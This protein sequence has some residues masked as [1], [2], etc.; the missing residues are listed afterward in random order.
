MIISLL[1]ACG[2]KEKNVVNEN[3][4]SIIDNE[5]L[6]MTEANKLVKEKI[7]IAYKKMGLGIEQYEISNANLVE[8]VSY[9]EGGTFDFYEIKFRLKPQNPEQVEKIEKRDQIEFTKDEEGWIVDNSSMGDT[10]ISAYNDGKEIYEILWLSEKELPRTE[11]DEINFNEFV[12]YRYEEVRPTKIEEEYT[13]KFGDAKMSIGENF[14]GQLPLENSEVKNEVAEDLLNVYASHKEIWNSEGICVETVSYFEKHYEPILR[15]FTSNPQVETNRGIKVGSTD[16]EVF[17]E[18]GK[19]NLVFSSNTFGGE[20]FNSFAEQQGIFKENEDWACYGF[21]GKDDTINYIAFFMN[22][23]KVIAIEMGT[24]FDYKPFN[25]EESEYPLEVEALINDH[26]DEPNVMKYDVRL[27]KIKDSINGSENLNALIQFD[28]E[29]I[30]DYSQSGKYEPSS[31][32]FNYPWVDIDYSVS[33]LGEVEVLNI[34]TTYSS[35]L[36]SGSYRYVNS[37]Y[38]DT[39]CGA[40][41]SESAAFYKL[42]YAKEDI[43][44][45][46]LYQYDEFTDIAENEEALSD[47]VKFYFNETGEPCFLMMDLD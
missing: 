37:Y 9:S 15:M 3:E 18:Y 19:D 42:G 22:Q 8:Q 24:G 21:T 13:F 6:I 33:N 31:T 16:K 39:T 10:Y 41:L 11:K 2:L 1:G 45:Y 23:G 40:R 32:G 25:K 29:Q 35:A 17:D 5:K 14:K 26:I 20:C 30:I 28:F 7:L 44:K 38:Y 36:G 12:T 47:Y 27:P 34:F 4:N 43:N 46:L